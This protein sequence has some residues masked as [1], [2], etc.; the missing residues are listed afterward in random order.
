M[1]MSVLSLPAS[2][3]HLY[4]KHLWNYKP[5]SW[6]DSTASTF[7]L[8]AF[9][10]VAPFVLLTL[11]DVASYVIARTLGVIDQ[12]KASTS[13]AEE[14]LLEDT[15][16]IVIQDESSSTPPPTPPPPPRRP[17]RKKRRKRRATWSWRAWGCSPQARPSPRRP[18]SRGSTR[19]TA[20]F[21]TTPRSAAAAAEQRRRGTPPGQLGRAAAGLRRSQYWTGTPG[22]RTRGS[23]CGGGHGQGQKQ[24]KVLQMQKTAVL[25]DGCSL[26][27]C[28]LAGTG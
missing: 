9:A 10:V 20:P 2:L 18:R 12:T 26:R 4:V 5:G 3:W 8:L 16:T 28:F 1:G 13:G 24:K 19:A 22:L 17:P 27:Q 15:P 11:L 23:C 7:R 6:V 21:R 14:V 25:W